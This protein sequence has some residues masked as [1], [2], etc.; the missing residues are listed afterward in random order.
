MDRHDPDSEELIRDLLT[1]WRE[2]KGYT[3]LQVDDLVPG[4]TMVIDCYGEHFGILTAGG[5][6]CNQKQKELAELIGH[7]VDIAAVARTDPVARQRV[8][9]QSH[10]VTINVYQEARVTL[11]SQALVCVAD[12]AAQRVYRIVEGD[13]EDTDG[14]MR[15]EDLIEDTVY[16]ALVHYLQIQNEPVPAMLVQEDELRQKQYQSLTGWYRARLGLYLGTAHFAEEYCN[17]LTE[18][19]LGLTPAR[20]RRLVLAYYDGHRRPSDE[21]AQDLRALA[22]DSRWTA[23]GVDA[24]LSGDALPALRR[25]IQSQF[26]RAIDRLLGGAAGQQRA[27]EILRGVCRTFLT[28]CTLAPEAR[29]AFLAALCTL[30]ANPPNI[31]AVANAFCSQHLPAGEWVLQDRIFVENAVRLFLA[32]AQQNR[33]SVDAICGEI[34]QQ[35]IPDP[36][37]RLFSPGLQAMGSALCAATGA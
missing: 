19:F 29:A 15:L 33:S 22:P 1:A 17:C 35:G 26:V 25:N 31:D 28:H 27:A 9:T 18:A 12:D 3:T 37:A 21:V 32:I 20:M 11:D 24:N 16:A 10:A 34:C 14:P 8:R 7:C 6:I 36:R 5:E 4:V 13:I 2:K 23:G 30:P